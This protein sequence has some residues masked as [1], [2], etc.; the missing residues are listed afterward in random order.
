MTAPPRPPCANPAPAVHDPSPDIRARRLVA[1]GCGHEGNQDWEAA[2]AAYQ[3]AVD[4]EPQDP[5]VRYFACNNLGFSLIQLGRFDEAEE[6]CEA[7]IFTDPDRHNAHKN[8]GLA[9]QGQGRWLDAALSLAEAARLQPQDT[10]AWL[11]LQKLFAA[12]PDLVG[13]SPALGQA[14]AG[15]RAH[16]EAD[17]WLPRLN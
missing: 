12:R 2:I 4:L 8:L 16:Y 10:R 14:I 9:R 11:H 15:V 3:A 13:Q 17:G 7:A 6:H 5:V 1:E